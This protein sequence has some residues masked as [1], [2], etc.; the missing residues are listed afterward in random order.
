M[1]IDIFQLNMCMRC[2]IERTEE[3]HDTR[4]VM[5]V[6]DGHLAR[7]EDDGYVDHCD[8]FGLVGILHLLRG[9]ANRGFSSY[10]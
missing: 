1:T 4:P 9:E 7:P 5:I 10:E 6:M 8:P 2:S 3:G